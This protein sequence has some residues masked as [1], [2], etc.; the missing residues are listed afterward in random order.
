[1]TRTNGIHPLA[2]EHP[3]AAPSAGTGPPVVVIGAGPVGLAAAAHLLKRGLEPLVLEAGS[4]VGANIA[5]WAHVRLFSPWCLALDPVSVRLL[6]QSGWAGPD[7]DALPT[8]ADL[9]ERYLEPLAAVPALASRIWLHTRVVAVARHDLD[10]VR[11]RAATNSP[12]WSGS[13]TTRASSTI[14]WPG[15]CS[16]LRAP[17]PSPPPWAPRGYL[18]WA[19]PTPAPGSSMGYRTFWAAT[20]TGMP[21]GG[22]WWSALA[23]RPRPACWP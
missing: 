19:S 13:A 20:A 21:V 11:S 6:D 2:I 7:P 12:S 1:M 22:R 9:L 17:G 15:R 10:K 4:Q 23:I 5:Q 14:C 18:P 8:G 3:D 16:T